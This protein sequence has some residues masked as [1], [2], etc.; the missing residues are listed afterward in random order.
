[1]ISYEVVGAVETASLSQLSQVQKCPLEEMV[2]VPGQEDC[3]EA[4][5]PSLSVRLMASVSRKENEHECELC[6]FINEV[7][8]HE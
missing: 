7:S 3:V 2:M 6:G 8:Y 1:M 5:E 4:F